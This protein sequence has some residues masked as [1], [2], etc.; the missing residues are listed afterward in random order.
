MQKNLITD[1][2]SCEFNLN[3]KKNLIVNLVEHKLL[4]NNSVSENETIYPLQIANSKLK[5]FLSINETIFDDITQT[6]LKDEFEIDIEDRNG[7]LNALFA[8]ILKIISET[9]YILT[10]KKFD[11][12]IE[13]NKLKTF[14]KQDFKYK[15]TGY[16]ISN[17]LK[18]GSIS[19]KFSIVIPIKFLRNIVYYLTKEDFLKKE[20]DKLP[21]ILD[22][23]RKNFIY[24]TYFFPFD[25]VDFFNN[26]TDKELQ[27]ILGL[28]FSGN[29]ITYD[30]LYALAVHIEN[31][32]ERVTNS[33]S[34]RLRTEFLQAIKDKE[35][36]LKER[37]WVQIAAYHIIINL[38]ILF[39][40]NKFESP[41]IN[42]FKSMYEIVRI[43]E[44]KN[45]FAS[46]SFTEWLK[47]MKSAGLLMKVYSFLDATTN[48]QAFISAD[49]VAL[50][51]IKNSISKRAFGFL[52]EEIEFE[53]IHLDENK[54]IKARYEFINCYLDMLFEKKKTEDETRLDEDK[55]LLD[56]ENQILRFSSVK[57]FNF[58]VEYV[59][60]I[61]FYIVMIKESTKLQRL[62]IK[63]LSP[64]V[65]YFMED[66]SAGKIQ[67]NFAFGDKTQKTS[68][69]H[70]LKT[71]FKLDKLE[72]INLK[73]DKNNQ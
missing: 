32:F 52:T 62:I 24:K 30:M 56:L 31:G 6:T 21:K 20:A 13:D 3:K 43:K 33:L 1:I 38:K 7:L 25:I 10:L 41:Y 69:N 29:L 37:R 67:L 9:L 11:L 40:Q 12:S 23:T 5:M 71:I 64:P 39:E 36:T 68:K 58:L 61:D 55:T 8:D 46:K 73:R 22:E 65:K 57:E 44:Y 16:K 63:N 2:F 47:E 4:A 51:I 18:I 54:E 14:P 34:K 28:F 42:K 48:T 60:A 53:K 19:L 49:D 66:L 27:K 70:I 72:M 45:F 17:K 50:E 35:E 26:L 59:G 15:F